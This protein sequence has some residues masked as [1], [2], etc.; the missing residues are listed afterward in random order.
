MCAIL[1]IVSL[2]INYNSRAVTAEGRLCEYTMQFFL[3]LTQEKPLIISM[4]NSII[5]VEQSY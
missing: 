1:N 2:T 4:V 5:V 3:V